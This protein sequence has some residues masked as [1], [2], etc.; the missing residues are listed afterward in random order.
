MV[1][2]T[3]PK[4]APPSRKY[5]PSETTVSSKSPRVVLCMY[6]HRGR[7]RPLSRLHQSC[8]A[9]LGWTDEGVRPYAIISILYSRNLPSCG[10]TAR[11]RPTLKYHASCRDTP[12]AETAFPHGST[13]RSSGLYSGNRS[14]EHCFRV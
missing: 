1:F 6:R 2:G 4:R 12:S 3:T 14:E 13:H 5:V 11:V 7:P 8:R 9:S 10:T